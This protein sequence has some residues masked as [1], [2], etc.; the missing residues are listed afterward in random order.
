MRTLRRTLRSLDYGQG[1]LPIRKRGK[2]RIR[3]RE[4]IAVALGAAVMALGFCLAGC[5]DHSHDGQHCVQSHDEQVILY[6]VH[7]NQYMSLPIYGTQSVCD[8]WA[9]DATPSR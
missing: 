6:F 2:M 3:K 9:P 5:S 4:A 8:K 7:P 1:L